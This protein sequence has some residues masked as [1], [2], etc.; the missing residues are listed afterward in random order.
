MSLLERF[1]EEID[2]LGDSFHKE[3]S[4]LAA[5]DRKDYVKAAEYQH[6]MMILQ[7]HREFI[8]RVKEA[9]ANN[10][11]DT[12]M[13]GILNCIMSPSDRPR[14]YELAR[15]DAAREHWKLVTRIIKARDKA[16]AST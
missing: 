3:E 13:Q 5:I 4:Y 15:V 10:T 6:D 9:I 16:N 8:P 12:L 14:A 7:Y 2:W 1:E 11:L